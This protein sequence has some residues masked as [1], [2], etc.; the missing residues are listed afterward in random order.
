LLQRSTRLP[1]DAL[2]YATLEW[3][4]IALLLINGLLTY[5][6]AVAREPSQHGD[7]GTWGH[8]GDR[9]G[10]GRYAEQKVRPDTG[11][12]LAGRPDA[13]L[14]DTKNISYV[15]AYVYVHLNYLFS[16]IRTNVCI[17]VLGR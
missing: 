15:H 7:V 5:T 3:V 2:A 9:K 1:E 6:I 10:R 4:F 17:F 16:R 14:V 13:S 12:E 8:V 11:L